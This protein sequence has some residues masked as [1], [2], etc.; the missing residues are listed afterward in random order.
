VVRFHFPPTN[1]SHHMI[2]LLAMNLPIGPTPHV[3]SFSYCSLIYIHFPPKIL[4]IFRPNSRRRRGHPNR[5]NA[6]ML[7]L[8]VC[9]I[10]FTRQT[11]NQA[12]L[13]PA[14][15]ILMC[16]PPQD[17]TLRLLG[18]S[19]VLIPLSWPWLPRHTSLDGFL[20]FA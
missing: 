19:Y 6:G 1:H 8:L 20:L 16:F 11:T 7:S 12:L 13:L 2:S 14:S 10:A 18:V 15:P 17:Y 5:I 4:F 9:S 3:F